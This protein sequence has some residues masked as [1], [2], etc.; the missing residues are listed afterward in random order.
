MIRARAHIS[1]VVQGVGFRPFVHRVAARFGLVGFVHNGTDGA[2]IEAQGDAGDVDRFFD[3]IRLE[4][5]P[6]ARVD[7]VVT[8][9][10][11]L[12]GET[13]FSIAESRRDALKRPVIPADLAVC[14]A[15]LAE[16]SSPDDR[17]YRYPFTSCAR[18]GPRFTIIAQIPYDRPSTTMA[19]FALC[20]ACAREY[21]DPGDRRF[22]AEP[23]ACPACGP[24]L[25]AV[26]PGGAAL[27]EGQEA[28]ER[29]SSAL[30][31]G[32]I[33]ALKGL[34]GYQLLADASSDDAVAL[35]RARKHRDEKPFA[36]MFPSLEAA[37]GA[38]EITPAI[39]ARLT[40]P[41]APIVLARKRDP[42]PACICISRA[43]APEN[44]Y[45]GIMIPSTP[46][47]HLL[48][49]SFGAPLVCTSGN[50]SE[51]PMCITDEEASSRL[52]GI[53]DLFLMHD[54]SIVRPV[55]DS[56][57]RVGPKGP[58]LLRRARGYAPLARPFPF[59]DAPVILA[60]GGHQKSTIALARG[61]EVTVSQHLGDL[62]SVEGAL[63]VER[64][65]ADW[66]AFFGATPEVIACDHHPDYESSK[67]ARRLAAKL[68]ARLVTVQHHH[69]HVASC[70]AEHALEGPVL[71]LAW[72]GA[73]LGDD[74]TLWGG[75]ALVVSESGVR[76]AA[77]LRPFSLPGGERAMREPARAAFGVLYE[78]GLRGLDAYLPS[79][80]PQ[81]SRVLAT[82][83]A[84][85]INAPR[86]TSAGRLFDAIAAIAGV[87]E[88]ASF[89]G[90][91]AMLL[92]WAA[93]HS[94]G[95]PPYPFPLRDGDPMIGDWGPL[96]LA[97]LD[98]RCKGRSPSV[99]AARFH[100]AL[101]ELAA[102]VAAR[103]GITRVVL[104]G[105]C[106]QNGILTARVTDA[107][108]ARGFMVYA[109]ARFPPN[110]GGLSLG[111]AYVAARSSAMGG[112]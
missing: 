33:V 57:V 30:A 81:V 68:G 70:M 104:S 99:I 65:V 82:M 96:V 7:H 10:L 47:H 27:A 21:A 84:Q 15:C 74:G 42:A 3:I 9:P 108:T 50:L 107:L 41:E 80:S 62:S 75:E 112:G 25:R 86:T 51:E 56:V 91:A 44:P 24:V 14:E 34:G 48:L 73:G 28:L 16:V 78:M 88:R 69:A 58:V 17:R 85:K 19:A 103:V 23:I 53:A 63:L 76:R 109:H 93:E 105:G 61:G 31:E 4:A 111:Q 67:L 95:E 5:P 8:T 6:P 90:Q 66:L 13:A 72:D 43:V 101:A 98:D 64:T 40:S 79:L 26:S 52:G 22:H 46:L 2:H 45:L 35:L 49:S 39:E 20:D 77:H 38:C 92:E 55:D 89:E 12:G 59:P 71:G 102:D 97:A 54:R 36:V 100:G 1:G 11:P 37:R 87:R 94:G 18:C 32:R 110:D 29:A 83:I 106:F 60:L